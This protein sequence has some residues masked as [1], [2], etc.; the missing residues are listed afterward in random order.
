MAHGDK[1][2]YNNKSFKAFIWINKNWSG[3]IKAPHIEEN[4]GT[5]NLFSYTGNLFWVI[6]PNC[7]WQEGAVAEIVA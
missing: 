2:N 7:I 4:R 6:I 1:V 5:Q 3:G